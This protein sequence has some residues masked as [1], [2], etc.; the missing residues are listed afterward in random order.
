MRPWVTL[1]ILWSLVGCNSQDLKLQVKLKLLMKLK[2]A[3]NILIKSKFWVA[4]L[5][6]SDDLCARYTYYSS[7]YQLVN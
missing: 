7:F 4:F 2:I 6:Y 5:K 3:F 1:S